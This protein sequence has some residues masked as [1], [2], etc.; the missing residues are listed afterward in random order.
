MTL[1][2]RLAPKGATA[3]VSSCA[4]A[5]PLGSASVV[6]PLRARSPIST[7]GAERGPLPAPSPSVG[8]PHASRLTSG[9]AREDILPFVCHIRSHHAAA[10]SRA[11]RHEA[12]G[13]HARTPVATP[14]ADRRHLRPPGRSE[15]RH[16]AG[17]PV[18]SRGA[19]K[20]TEQTHAREPNA[21]RQRMHAP[22]QGPTG[23]AEPEAAF[24]R[25]RGCTGHRQGEVLLT[26]RWPAP[27]NGW[28]L[29][30]E[31]PLALVPSPAAAIVVVCVSVCEWAGLL[32]PQVVSQAAQV[33]CVASDQR[34]R[35]A[36]SASVWTG[37][38]RVQGRGPWRVR[39]DVVERDG[40]LMMTLSAR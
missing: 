17:R 21:P 36:P 14:L 19:H 34:S 15:V 40:G 1:V 3:R 39:W 26:M 4:P 38:W 35:R 27:A 18:G 6:A 31:P 13:G 7:A 10:G 20:H 2:A 12:P 37:R 8:T 5:G 16:A 24:C 28:L 23:G 22:P 30:R 29:T 11:L 9:V 25:Q 33:G 32:L